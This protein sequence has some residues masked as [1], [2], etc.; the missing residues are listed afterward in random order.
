TRA[1]GADNRGAA[2]NSCKTEGITN[3]MFEALEAACAKLCPDLQLF[4][5]WTHQAQNLKG[6][7]LKKVMLQ[8]VDEGIVCLPVHD[9]VAVP[10]RHQAWAEAAMVHAWTDAVGCDV[11]PRVKVDVAA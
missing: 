2:L 5:G 6:Q 10:Q 8:G 4:I 1:M 3:V 11:K 9:A 7:I